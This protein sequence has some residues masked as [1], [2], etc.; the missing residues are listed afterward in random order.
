MRQAD[1]RTDPMPGMVCTRDSLI[2]AD[3]LCEADVESEVKYRYRRF[4]LGELKNE[5]VLYGRSCSGVFGKEKAS[6]P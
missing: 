5:A 6:N 2:L 1:L 3:T 4:G